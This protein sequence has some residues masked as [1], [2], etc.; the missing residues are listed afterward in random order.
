MTTGEVVLFTW[1]EGLREQQELW[2]VPREQPRPPEPPA[3]GRADGRDGF[4]ATASATAAAAA[5]A[6]LSPELAA[7]AEIS[8]RIVHGQPFT[9]RKSTF[10]A[11]VAPITSADEVREEVSSPWVGRCAS[12][13][14]LA[15]T[16]AAHNLPTASPFVAATNTHGPNGIQVELV[17]DSLLQH[18]KIRSATHNIMAYRI[19]K[20]GRDAA[21]K[22]RTG[23]AT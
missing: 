4:Q 23:T 6:E 17:M 10:Q 19:I 15:A 3:G 13:S 16:P 22:V 8:G 7:M 2:Q 5:A 1:I 21:I 14:L 12:C 20:D 9:E 11:H 18:N